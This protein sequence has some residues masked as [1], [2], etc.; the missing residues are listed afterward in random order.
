[1]PFPHEWASNRA[2]LVVN[3]HHG[4]PMPLCPAFPCV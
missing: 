2:I 1:M 4:N 3:S